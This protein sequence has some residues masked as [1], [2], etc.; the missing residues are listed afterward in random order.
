MLRVCA[1]ITA[2]IV[3]GAC[4]DTE[5]MPESADLV[6]RNGTIL[7]LDAANRIAQAVA[8]KGAWIVA[9]GSDDEI[10][11]FVGESTRVIDLEGRLAI[12]G[13][14]EGHGHFM[15]LGTAKTVLDLT[16]AASWDE[17][18]DLVA[19]AVEEAQ[20]G[21]WIQGRGWHQEKWT[22]PPPGAVEGSNSASPET[23][24]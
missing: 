4:S 14:I 23:C 17:I 3:S 7:R 19:I 18:V 21:D 11:R 9:V 15:N 2:L 10:S 22:T 13:F 5:T 8:I 16:T 1:L 24:P 12:P 6:L 20:T